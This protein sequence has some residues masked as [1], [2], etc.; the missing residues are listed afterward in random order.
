MDFGH[1]VFF[2]ISNLVFLIDLTVQGESF[3]TVHIR[4]ILL[5]IKICSSDFYQSY[6]LGDEAPMKT[7]FER[8]SFEFLGYFKQAWATCNKRLFLF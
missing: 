5:Y 3:V 7:I 2:Q 1:R 8:R 6:Y 4:I